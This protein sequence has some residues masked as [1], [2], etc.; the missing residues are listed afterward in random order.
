MLRVIVFLYEYQ[1]YFIRLAL[2]AKLQM[3]WKI[4]VYEEEKI[5]AKEIILNL[6][7]LTRE[8]EDESRENADEGRKTPKQRRRW[9]R[10]HQFHH[11]Q[12]NQ[13]QQ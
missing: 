9:Q 6:V 4:N 12:H 2:M 3:K 10:N 11:K 1:S 7:K 5:E 13:W 8:L